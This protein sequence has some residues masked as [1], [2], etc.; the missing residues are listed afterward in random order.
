[1]TTKNSRVSKIAFVISLL[2][3]SSFSSIH[4]YSRGE[5]V[6]HCNTGLLKVAKKV[7]STPEISRRDFFQEFY[8]QA[9]LCASQYLGSQPQKSILMKTVTYIKQYFKLN[10]EDAL[11][12]E[13]LEKSQKIKIQEE[14]VAETEHL[15]LEKKHLEKLEARKRELNT[16]LL[17]SLKFGIESPQL[18]KATQDFQEALVEVKEH[19][20]T[21]RYLEEKVA[22]VK[23]KLLSNERLVKIPAFELQREVK[24]V[25]D[26][27]GMIEKA[28]KDTP[29]VF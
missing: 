1:M 21:L 5:G 19:E 26:I 12:L 29:E 8:S 4:S 9:L 24:I 20:N 2:V 25:E 16:K 7:S 10:M 15:K 3:L 27:V 6:K 22:I 28:K 17:S 11:Q 23:T 18:K 13:E 14:F